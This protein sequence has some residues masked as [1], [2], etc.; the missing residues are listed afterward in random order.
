[1]NKLI[2]II[3]SMLFFFSE[4]N[5]KHIKAAKVPAAVKNAFKSMYPAVL[6][7]TWE[8]EHGQYEAEFIL[9]GAENSVVFYADGQ[10]RATE[11]EIPASQLPVKVQEYVK[12]NFPGKKI[13]EAS[14][15]MF[16]DQK[17]Y[18]VQIGRKDYLVTEN[19]DPTKE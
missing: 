16:A 4:T 17:I 10:L 14:I 18:E 9:D 6:K 2:I 3:F 8:L 7:N 19:G 5:A 15:I 1:M 13:R 11:R 12:T